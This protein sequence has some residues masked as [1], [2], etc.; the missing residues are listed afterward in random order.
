MSVISGTLG[1]ILGSRA[2]RAQAE[3]NLRAARE[4]N[5]MNYRMF[6]EGRGATGHAFLPTYFGGKEQQLAQDAMLNYDQMRA[7]MGSPEEQLRS[8]QAAMD[9]YQPMA[10]AARGTLA[11][12]Y[13]GNMTTARLAYL[14]PVLQARTAQARGQ[15]SAIGQGLAQTQ[16]ALAAANARK[17]F[18]GTGSFANNRLLAA[19][20]G[21]R[22]AA[23]GVL[24]A[25]NLAN[26]Q[27]TRGVY[28][29]GNA[30]VASIFDAWLTPFKS[31]SME[32]NT[33]GN[34]GST[35]HI[36]F[37]NL[38]LPGF[39]FVQDGLDYSTRTHHTNQDVYE[40][41]QPDDMMF[42]AAVL[43]AFAWQAAQRDQPLPRKPAP[44]SEGGPRNRGQ[45][46]M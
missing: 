22:Q 25:A 2:Q 46:C 36:A 32:I 10:D 31:M 16:N 27:D 13:N 17:G 26:A 39:Q 45:F 3:A 5:E 15:Q 28:D 37:D 21:A 33:I 44:F 7:M 1:A 19:T 42:N 8:Y 24:G 30:R 9:Q 14:D 29:Q 11:D 43:A 40:R 35:D 4:T 20:T 41:L 23:S 12:V 18:T 34:T 6:N 38:G